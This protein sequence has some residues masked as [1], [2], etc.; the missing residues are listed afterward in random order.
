MH[1]LLSCRHHIPP[2]QHSRPNDHTPEP[3]PQF[4]GLKMDG[5]ASVL[6]AFPKCAFKPVETTGEIEKTTNTAQARIQCR[7]RGLR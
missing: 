6:D 4:V 3:L 7:Q 1:G 2:Q 5:S